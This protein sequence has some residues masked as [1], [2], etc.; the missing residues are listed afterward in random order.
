VD[1]CADALVFLLKTYSD[2]QHVNVGSGYD[3]SIRELAALIC[4][5]VGYTGDLIFD[6]S[7]PDGTPRKL[8][9]TDKLAQLGWKS[10]IGL[11]DGIAQVYGGYTRALKTD[12]I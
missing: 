3:I 2:A 10:K 9:S 6:R 12:L 11:R 4:G 5:V 8:M 1:D 7:R